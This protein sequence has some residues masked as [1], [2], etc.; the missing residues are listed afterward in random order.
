MFATEHLRASGHLERLVR[1]A[2]M[3]SQHRGAGE[4][5]GYVGVLGA[6]PLLLNEQRTCDEWRGVV[7]IA[8]VGMQAVPG[9]GAPP[10]P[11]DDPDRATFSQMRSARS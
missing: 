8:G 11:W 6:Q 4:R 7:V 9:S 1:R 3:R 2:G 5:S 10:P